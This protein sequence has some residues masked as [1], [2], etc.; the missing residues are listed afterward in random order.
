MDAARALRLRSSPAQ[1]LQ[2]QAAQGRAAPAFAARFG[3]A[4]DARQVLAVGDELGVVSLVRLTGEGLT[5]VAALEAH[6]NACFDVRWRPCG[7]AT[8]LATAGGDGCAHVLDTSTGA[9]LVRVRGHT[10]S[11]KALAW[12]HSGACLAIERARSPSPFSI[13]LLLCP[14]RCS[15]VFACSPQICC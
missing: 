5:A 7:A 11:V 14:L 15:R 6:P 9:T 13:D 2:L 12:T 4:G 8:H 10:G 3:C 1:Q